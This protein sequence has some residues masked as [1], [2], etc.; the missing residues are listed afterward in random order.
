M[1]V[2]QDLHGLEI[3]PDGA[4]WYGK[5]GQEH[6]YNSIEAGTITFFV[7]KNWYWRFSRVTNT[8]NSNI[9]SN[10]WLKFILNY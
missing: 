1:V 9:E 2:S 4:T 3:S 6:Y 5:L 8:T 10:Y 7:P